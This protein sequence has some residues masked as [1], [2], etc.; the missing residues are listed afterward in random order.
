[1]N[2]THHSNTTNNNFYTPATI[3]APL[4]P[5]SRNLEF[6]YFDCAKNTIFSDFEHTFSLTDT[7]SHIQ[8]VVK[9]TLKRKGYNGS[10]DSIILRTIDQKDLGAKT[11]SLQEVFPI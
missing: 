7:L 2:H 10:R 11:K 3:T 9:A 1:M 8:D 6:I 4:S 5:D